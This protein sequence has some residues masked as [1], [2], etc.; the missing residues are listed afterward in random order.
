ML[1]EEIL[2]K[3]HAW[4]K[5]IKNLEGANDLDRAYLS[6][7][8]YSNKDILKKN[9]DIISPYKSVANKYDFERLLLL[10]IKDHKQTKLLNSVLNRVNREMLTDLLTP[11]LMFDVFVLLG[12]K[13][14]KETISKNVYAF[15]NAEEFNDYLKYYSNWHNKWNRENVLDVVLKKNL[16]VVISLDK[17]NILILEIKDF[18]AAQNIGTQAWCISREKKFFDSH[19]N[20]IDKLFFM[21]DFN[22]DQYDS[23][24]LI[25]VT[26]P[27]SPVIRF[28]Y[29]FNN[30]N[31]PYKDISLI[32]TFKE[33]MHNEP[34]NE[35]KFKS[36]VSLIT[37]PFEQFM[38]FYEMNFDEDAEFIFQEF[39]VDGRYD[40]FFLLVINQMIFDD[41]RYDFLY[42]YME[43]HE[44]TNKEKSKIVSTIAELL[45]EMH[46]VYNPDFTSKLFEL[47]NDENIEIDFLRK[48]VE[49][50]HTA[51]V[52]KDLLKNIINKKEIEDYII[53]Y[54]FK[55]NKD[56]LVL[57]DLFEINA[58]TELNFVRLNHSLDKNQVIKIKRYIKDSYKK[59]DKLYVISNKININKIIDNIM[60]IFR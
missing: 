49:A 59:T 45:T 15:N 44:L 28:K 10:I 34:F 42:N 11:D 25:G 46:H 7:M 22:K 21:F 27:D 2:N 9:V 26:I 33:I 47:I 24:S 20:S 57:Q 50:P 48:M 53:E 51:C 37:D 54:I 52:V 4:L 23:T 1:Y 13:Q 58:F 39:L 32:K 17:N 35:E 12:K 56:N 6:W 18:Y 19:K 31:Q 40:D 8:I 41:K 3:N 38:V 30:V 43:N 55:I 16:N 5:F 29:S 60:A 14:F 36:N